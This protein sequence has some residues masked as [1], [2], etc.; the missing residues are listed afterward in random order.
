MTVPNLYEQVAAMAAA[1]EAE[2]TEAR[3]RGPE[4]V[5]VHPSQADTV[6]ALLATADP[7]D[8]RVMES[9]MVPSGTAYRLPRTGGAL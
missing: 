4:V 5:L 2:I 6:R 8:L 1:L 7:R 3:E 9:P